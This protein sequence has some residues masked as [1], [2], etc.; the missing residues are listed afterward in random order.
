MMKVLLI[1]SI[2]P[3]F[4]FNPQVQTHVREVP[5]IAECVRL[6]TAFITETIPSSIDAKAIAFSCEVQDTARSG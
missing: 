4:G 3:L 5:S 1:L 6:G 2:A